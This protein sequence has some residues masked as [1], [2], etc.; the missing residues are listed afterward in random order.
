MTPHQIFFLLKVGGPSRASAERACFQY[1]RERARCTV[2]TTRGTRFI[3]PPNEQEDIAQDVLI[4]IFQR[5]SYVADVVLEHDVFCEAGLDQQDVTFADPP[6]AALAGAD[7]LVEALVGVML[8]NRFLDVSGKGPDAPTPAP[9]PEP[10]PRG[11]EAVVAAGLAVIQEAAA[12]H[13]AAITNPTWRSQREEAWGQIVGLYLGS[14]TMGPILRRTIDG[15]AE[16]ARRESS[17]PEGALEQA[18]DRVLMRHSHVRKYVKNTIDELEALGPGGR[19]PAGSAGWTR[20]RADL[21]RKTISGLLVRCQSSR[22][23][24]SSGERS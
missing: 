5:R 3:I 18:R 7:R 20:D 13:F 15:D 9:A 8:A 24:P 4:K 10:P 11:A 14:V 19:T 23:P 16:L 2:S 12:A 1:V 22:R 6:P 17:D 21:A